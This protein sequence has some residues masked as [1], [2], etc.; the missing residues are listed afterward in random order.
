MIP[1]QR[2]PSDPAGQP[3]H[4]R[5]PAAGD[6]ERE[7]TA[8]LQDDVVLERIRRRRPVTDPVGCRLARWRDDVETRPT[9]LAAW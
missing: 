9:P 7:A 3:T 8:M 1:E 2:A 4:P 6:L 5:P